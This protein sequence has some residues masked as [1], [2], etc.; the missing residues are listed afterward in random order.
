MAVPQARRIDVPQE[1]RDLLRD[2]EE[3]FR[4]VSLRELSPYAGKWIAV[5]GRRVV[6][7][8]NTMERLHRKLKEEKL[9][10]VSISYRED[11]RYLVIYA[12][13]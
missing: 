2:D 6:A 8:A 4:T 10:L 1:V 11:P 5:K 13:H 12:V 3:F 7:A 9:T